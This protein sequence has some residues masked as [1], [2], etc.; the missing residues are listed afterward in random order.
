M[1]VQ[2]IQTNFLV[3]SEIKTYL[4]EHWE[5]FSLFQKEKI[6]EYLS[7][8]DEIQQEALKKGIQNDPHF[9]SHLELS[10]RNAAQ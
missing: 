8:F 1:I 9:L 6:V 3:S 7:L 10:I 5:S 2:K 4:L